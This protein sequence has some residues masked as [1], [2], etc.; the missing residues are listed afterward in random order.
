MPK[1]AAIIDPSMTQH[2]IDGT[3][4]GFSATRIE[5]LGS[6]EYTLVGIAADH[7]GSTSGFQKSIEKTIQEVVRACQYSPRV[8]NL[9]LRVLVFDSSLDEIH[10]FRPLA[11]CNTADYDGCANPGGMTALYDATMNIVESVTRYGADLTK[12]DFGVNGIVF[13]ITDGQENA[14]K[15][16]IQTIKAA[17]LDAIKGE[18]LESIRTI[19]IGLNT[20]ATAGLDQ[21]LQSFK[22]DVGFDQYVG[23]ADVS[24]KSLA[25]LAAFISKSVSSQSQSLGTG[26]ASQSLTF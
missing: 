4:Y 3:G 26:S 9:M 7:S 1:F 2:Q 18:K 17:I 8:D 23:V 25:K 12:Q 16:T 13:V 19:L 20:A 6:T 22:N 11:Q 10:G 14:S 21:Y 15:M 5:T 24:P